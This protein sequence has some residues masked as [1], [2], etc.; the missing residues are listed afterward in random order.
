MV[1]VIAALAVFVARH[2][3]VDNGRPDWL[4]VALTA[5]PLVAVVRFKVG[6]VAVVATCAAIGLIASL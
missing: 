3:A 2:A 6:V 4:V 5:V 1:G